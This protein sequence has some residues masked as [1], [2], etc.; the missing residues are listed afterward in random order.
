ML[1][2]YANMIALAANVDNLGVGM[3]YGAR[4]IR[5]SPGANFVIALLSF[6]AVW[7]TAGLGDMLNNLITFSLA[8]RIGAVIISIVGIWMMVESFLKDVSV[9]VGSVAVMENPEKADRDSSQEIDAKEG[10]LL[11]LALSLNDGAVGLDAGLVGFPAIPLA[12]LASLYS[13]CI[14]GAGVYMGRT[15]A[16]RYFGRWTA[17]LSGLLMLVIGI[18]QL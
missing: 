6:L 15:Y 9:Y 18:H 12:L 11:G 4:K 8:N 17:L 14:I 2:L 7:L 13:Y 3:A 16:A 10:L 1:W 5:I